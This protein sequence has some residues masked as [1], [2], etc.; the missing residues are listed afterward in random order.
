MKK[1][2]RVLVAVCLL[3][4]GAGILAMIVRENIAGARDFIAYWSAGQQLRH[5]ANPYSWTEVLRLERAAG[6]SGEKPLIM[7]NPPVALFLTV[8]LGFMSANAGSILWMFLLLGCVI[9]S[10]RMIWIMQGRSDSRLHL[11]GYC[12]APLM[13]CLMAGQVG[14]ILLLGVTLFLFWHR[15]R[16]FLGGAC[17]VLCAIK[18]HLFVPFGIVL[19]IWTVSARAYRL[20]GGV[21]AAVGASCVVAWWLDPHAWSQYAAMMRIAGISGEIVPTLSEMFRH[22]VNGDWVWLQFVPEVA[23]CVWAVWYFVTRRQRWDWMQHGLLVLLVSVLC[24]PYALFTDEAMLLPAVLIAAYRAQA[25]G[26][27]LVP[28][29]LAAGIAIFEVFL[30]VQITSVYYLWTVPAWLV[31]YLYATR[32]ER[33]GSPVAA[34]VEA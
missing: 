6:F 33:P 20:L 3:A 1:A 32:A 8:P 12:F 25:A 28:F 19:V 13:F 7:R 11:L 4:V 27:S 16:P 30:N 31:W 21:A 17:M 34:G 9:G 15:T 26:R 14:I 24:S 23:G 29:G 18:P 10:I 22:A 5:G 2:L